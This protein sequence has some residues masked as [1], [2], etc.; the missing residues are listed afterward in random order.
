MYRNRN[1]K[2]TIRKAVKSI[3]PIFVYYFITPMKYLKI[4]PAFA[5]FVLCSLFFF[6]SCARKA[7][8]EKSAVVPSASGSVKVKKDNNNNYKVSLEVRDLTTPQ[9]LVPARKAYLVWNEADNGVFNI[10]Q[11]VSSRSFLARGF[12]ASLTVSTPNKPKKVFITAED[13]TNTLAPSS[14]VIL[15]TPDF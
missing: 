13:N 9:N 12:K 15:T 2:K 7:A 5:V 11:L 4:Q 3:Q 6:V 14:Q 8:F 10:G 1:C